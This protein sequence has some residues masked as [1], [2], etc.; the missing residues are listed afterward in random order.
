MIEKIYK[1]SEVIVEHAICLKCCLG[2]REDLS[3]ESCGRIDRYFDQHI[4]MNRRRL[5]MLQ[6]EQTDVEPW[7]SNC[8]VTGKHIDQGDEYQIYAHCDG[9]HMLFSGYP[10]MISAETLSQLQK[11]L[12]KKT[13]DFMNDFVGEYHGLPGEFIDNFDNSP[14]LLL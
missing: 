2:K 10:F 9:E 1:G 13:R 4:D 11:L 8:I 6:A 7:M 5:H 3:K 14:M 12:S